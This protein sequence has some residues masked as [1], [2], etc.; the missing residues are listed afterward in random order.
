MANGVVRLDNMSGTTDGSKL[1]SFIYINGSSKETEIAN[2][3]V[4]A[5]HERV[6]GE[7]EIWKGVAVDADVDTLGKIVLV[8]GVELPYDSNYAN[9]DEWVNPAGKPTRGYILEKGDEFSVTSDCFA[10]AVG[11]NKVVELADGIKLKAVASATS[12]VTQIGK[13]VGTDVVGGLTY[14]NIKVG[15]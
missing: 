2:G 4:V 5:I 3:S 6:D 1:V 11:S 12:G 7:R 9:L 15:I 14:Y 10:S 8:A 13:I